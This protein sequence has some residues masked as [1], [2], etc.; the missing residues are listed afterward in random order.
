MP[1]EMSQEAAD[2]L[3]LAEQITAHAKNYGWK[4]VVAPKVNRKF[5]FVTLRREL[6]A[7]YQEELKA[8]YAIDPDKDRDQVS[9]T[10]NDGVTRVLDPD[11]GDVREVIENEFRVV[12][13]ADTSG[14]ADD[15]APE[16][17]MGEVD[18]ARVPPT[19][20][21]HSA[22]HQ[23]VPPTDA[24]HTDTDDASAAHMSQE[25]I[26]DLADR[27]GLTPM[28]DESAAHLEQRTVPEHFGIVPEADPGAVAKDAMGHQAAAEK[29]KPKDAVHPT[30]SQQDTYAA[31]RQQHTNP[32]RNW[33]A[34]AS[35]LSTTEILTKLGV[36]RKT[37]NKVEISW[38]NS[39]SGALD[40]AIVDGAAEKYPPHI[41]PADFDPEENGEDLRILHFI[42]TGGGFRSVAVARIKKI[43]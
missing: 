13:L 42:Q 40:S 20:A 39:L 6:D 22:A 4:P 29:A 30:W 15:V 43:G 37:N 16:E 32:H 36:N 18:S 2:A 41:T 11:S 26:D 19:S 17:D 10:G 24:A 5:G 3:D 25:D 28:E 14:D 33:S 34:V 35:P 1:Q 27:F 12:A 8:F 21:A 31:V 9:Y 7:E 23:D 38:L